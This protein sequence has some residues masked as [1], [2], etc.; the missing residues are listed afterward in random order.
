MTERYN[1]MKIEIEILDEM[2]TMNIYD[3]DQKFFLDEQ[4]EVNYI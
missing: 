1:E 2:M 4:I 3:F